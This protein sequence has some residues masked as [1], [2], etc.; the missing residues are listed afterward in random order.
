MKAKSGVLEKFKQFHTAV[1]RETERQLRCVRSDNGGEYRGPLND[2]TENLE[3]GWKRLFQ[4][5]RSRMELLR[6]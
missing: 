1:D 5:H 6:E 3:S 2:T 4:R